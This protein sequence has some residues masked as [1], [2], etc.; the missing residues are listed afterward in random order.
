MLKI[1]A[2]STFFLIGC[3]IGCAPI[4][5][6]SWTSTPVMQTAANQYYEARIEPLK[7]DHNFFEYLRLTITS[8]TDENLEIDWNKTRYILN[9]R[10]Y[11]GFV[12]K[13]IDPEQIKNLTIPPDIVSAR[14]TFSKEIS[15]FKLLAGA[16]I[17]YRS[18]GV[19][20]S[21]FSPGVIPDGENGV[22]LVVRSNGKEVIEKITLN[23]IS[24]QTGK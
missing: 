11:G 24:T 22:Y 12:F 19:N 6:K 8:K 2:L 21:G 10:N 18:V 15:P 3:L 14:Q 20:E 1:K 7:K 9:G 5:T 16:P 17:R 23:I 13:G 4:Q